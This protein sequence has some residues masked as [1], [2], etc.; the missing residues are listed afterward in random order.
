MHLY[1]YLDYMLSS[2]IVCDTCIWG[3][4][5]PRKV[6]CLLALS[7]RCLTGCQG[8][9]T[10]DPG[11]SALCSGERERLKTL[12]FRSE[13]PNVQVSSHSLREL[14]PGPQYGPSVPTILLIVYGNFWAS[15]GAWNAR[16][17]RISHSQ[18][19]GIQ[20]GNPGT[21]EV[22]KRPSQE[23]R[24]AVKDEAGAI[25]PRRSLQCFN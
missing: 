5:Q 22:R 7:K 25:W 11:V 1:T 24:K 3:S 21:C 19:R 6:E 12:V 10:V 9:R 14:T 17:V 18:H 15:I 16:V 4:P 23:S 13:C 8:A 20:P 2:R